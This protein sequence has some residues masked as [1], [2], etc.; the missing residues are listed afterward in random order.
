MNIKNN[1]QNIRV[2][3]CFDKMIYQ[4]KNINR[5]VIDM[6]NLKIIQIIGKDVIG[7][8]IEGQNQNKGIR[9]LKLAK[10]T[11][12]FPDWRRALNEKKG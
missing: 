4:M 9:I 3:E 6:L 1:N 8:E 11:T 7:K 10:C 12:L 2:L 5:Y